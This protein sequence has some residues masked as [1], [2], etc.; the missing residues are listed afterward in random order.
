M[1][2]PVS[3][4]S[5]TRISILAVDDT[6]VIGHNSLVFIQWEDYFVAGISEISNIKRVDSTSTSNCPLHSLRKLEDHDAIHTVW[7]IRLVCKP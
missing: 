4:S 5:S 1:T 2:F 3:T 6:V 7:T